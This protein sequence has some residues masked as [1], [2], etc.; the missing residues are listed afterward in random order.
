MKKLLLFLF[1][2][3]ALVRSQ[4]TNIATLP[5]YTGGLDSAKVVGSIN[6]L[7]KNFWGVDLKRGLVKYTD[8]ASMFAGYL[9]LSALA[10]YLLAS[11]AANTY[12]PLGSYATPTQVAL[13]LNYADTANMLTNYKHWLAGYLTSTTGDARYYTKTLADARYLQSETDPKR[14][15]SIAVTGTGTKTITATLA[16]ATTVTA[17]FTD[18]QGTGGTGSSTFSGLTD[19]SLTSIT[20]GQLTRWNNSLSVWENFTPSYL[21][22]ETDPL[23]DTKLSS[24][25]T[26]N[27][28]QGATNKYFSNSLARGA[29]S[30]TGSISYN[31]TTGVFSYTTP[32]VISAFTNDAGYITSSALSPYL[33]SATAASTYATITALNAKQNALTLTTTGT[34][35]AATLSGSTLNIPQYSGGSA[36]LYSTTGANTD[37]AMTQ[38]ATTTAL[39]AKQDTAGAKIYFSS[40]DFYRDGATLATSLK[41]LGKADSATTTYLTATQTITNKIVAYTIQTLT[42]GATITWNANNG[43]IANVTI[44]GNR[45]LV[46]SNAIA[47]TYYQIKIKQDATGSRTITWPSGIKWIGGTAPALTTTAN[48]ED[49]ITLWY[50]G[51][52]YYGN[53]GLDYK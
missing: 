7:S 16:D 34:S 41:V 49:I 53:Y 31:S 22:S 8:T 21:T 23:F 42:D 44:G 47:N 15:V 3:P 1:F 10:P 18:L 14:I 52:N 51:T 25:T 2:I 40:T 43:T 48:A 12:Q 13:K 45:T 38:A 4:T 20:N 17:T 29:V 26:D 11:T 28:T 46:I 27:L 35:G 39:G 9:R 50:N 32:T 6:G 30:A 24:K 33:T 37:G 5:I 36:T 19:V